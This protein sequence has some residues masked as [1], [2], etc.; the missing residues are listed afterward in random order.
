MLPDRVS[1]PGPLTYKSGALPIALGGPA[2]C[3]SMFSNVIISD[4]ISLDL[5]DSDINS[6]KVS[7]IWRSV[8]DGQKICSSKGVSLIGI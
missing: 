3:C 6:E 8:S 4:V 2:I 5:W 7:L 1:N